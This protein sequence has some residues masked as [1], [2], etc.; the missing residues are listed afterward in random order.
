MTGLGDYIY[1]VINNVIVRYDI[2]KGSIQTLSI[3]IGKVIHQISC[4]TSI[5]IDNKDHI[6]L[7]LQETGSD[8]D[9]KI[10]AMEH[11]ET[12]DNYI[13]PSLFY[14]GTDSNHKFSE[15]ITSMVIYESPSINS[16]VVYVTSNSKVYRLSYSRNETG[17]VYGSDIQQK[18]SYSDGNVI[19][20]P[21]I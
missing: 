17:E 3:E 21:I 9:Y 2:V 7:A 14:N 12:L 4:I 16:N 1:I 15:A 11:K 20:T 18:Y 6:L 19:V 8:N 5:K 13:E 10:Y